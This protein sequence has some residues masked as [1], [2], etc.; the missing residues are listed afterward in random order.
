MFDYSSTEDY[1][2]IDGTQIPIQNVT[3]EKSCF[4]PDDPENP[5]AGH[6]FGTAIAK[7]LTFKMDTSTIIEGTTFVYHAITKDENGNGDDH[8]LGTFIATNAPVG[9][10]TGIT[11]VTAYDLMLNANIDY[12]S[13]LDY[14]L[15]PTLA[16]VLADVCDQAGLT[17]REGQTLPN[18]S[19]IV[20]SNPFTVGESCRQVIAAIAAITGSFAQ[21][22]EDELVFVTPSMTA[23]AVAEVMPQQYD[24]LDVQQATTAI[25]TVTMRNNITGSTITSGDGSGGILYIDDNQFATTAGKMSALI[26]G[27]L[28]AVNG[29]TY[30]VYTAKGLSDPTLECGD[31]MRI[32]DKDNVEYDSFMFSMT[33]KSGGVLKSG[34]TSAPAVAKAAVP[35]QYVPTPEMQLVKQAIAYTSQVKAATDAATAVLNAPGTSYVMLYPST[36]NPAEIYIMDNPDKD[37]AVNV[38]RFNALGWGLSTAGINGPYTIAAT[39]AGFVANAITTGFLSADRISGGTLSAGIVFAGTLNAASGTF[40][41]LTAG[42]ANAQR[43]HMGYTAQNEPIIEIYDNT[44]TLKVKITKDGVSVGNVQI[45]PYTSGTKSGIG[46]FIN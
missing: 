16:D 15:S 13:G 19:F 30:F 46:F 21:I 6:I 10:T 31:R 41:D 39:A 33:Y 5:K 42:L 20:E 17:L 1:I 25:N 4:Y 26:D 44:N 27:I 38:M 43:I 23:T 9:D 28:G 3:L 12:V 37:A 8:I 24:T 22:I 11:N 18:A 14:T 32:F 45:A 29:L 35:Y 40:T 2:E 7:K 34:E 36:A